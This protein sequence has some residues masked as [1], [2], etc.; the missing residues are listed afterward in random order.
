MPDHLTPRNSPKSKRRRSPIRVFVAMSF[1]EN[2]HPEL[3]DIW[4]AMKRAAAR[5]RG[6][7]DLRRIDEIE[8]DYE[9][10]SQVYKEIDAAD[11]MI[12]DFYLGSQ[13]VYLEYGYGKG[14]DKYIIS[15][16]REDTPLEFDVRGHRTLIYRNATDLE[17]K[18]VKC[19]NALHRPSATRGQS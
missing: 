1:R 15:T 2:E 12:A 17:A 6:D 4:H 9:I 10:L 16:C 14:R 5:A 18:L 3:V 7:F 13:N 11:L 19:L 8:G